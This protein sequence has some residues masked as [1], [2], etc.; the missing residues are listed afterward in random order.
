[1]PITMY[2]ASVPVFVRMLNNLAAIL[3]KAEQ[4]AAAHKI[5]PAVL[6]ATRLFPDMFPLAKQVQIAADAA[7][8]AGE[9]AARCPKDGTLAKPGTKFCPNCGTRMPEPAAVAPANC[10]QCG[11]PSNG[12]KFCSNCGTKLV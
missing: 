7:K 5:D 6:P 3:E 11:T 10:P 1:M 12:A 4:H 8:R 9:M 2:S